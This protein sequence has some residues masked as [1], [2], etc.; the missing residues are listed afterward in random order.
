MITALPVDARTRDSIE[1]IY[2]G[3]HYG[4][5][6]D[7]VGRADGY[8]EGDLVYGADRAPYDLNSWPSDFQLQ[9]R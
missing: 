4:G 7:S 1:R 9:G 6:Y 2:S 3:P 5:V 8:D